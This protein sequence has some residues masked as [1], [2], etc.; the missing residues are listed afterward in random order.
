MLIITPLHAIA[1]CAM[2]LMMF[3]TPDDMSLICRHAD[4]AMAFY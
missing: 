1:Y 4:A 3:S 2:L